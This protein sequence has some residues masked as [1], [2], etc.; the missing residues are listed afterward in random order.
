MLRLKLKKEVFEVEEA[1]NSFAGTTSWL[2]P[3]D[4]EVRFSYGGRIDTPHTALST[5]GV[6]FIRLPLRAYK[7]ALE[8]ISFTNQS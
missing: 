2:P 5:K 8:L 1:F 3:V 7:R 4:H 6:S